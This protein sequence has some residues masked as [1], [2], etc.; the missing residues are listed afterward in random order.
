MLRTFC[1]ATIEIPHF[2]HAPSTLQTPRDC[3]H[4]KKCSMLKV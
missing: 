1:Q 2:L 4:I 3:R